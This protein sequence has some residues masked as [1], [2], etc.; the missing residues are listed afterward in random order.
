M[1]NSCLS[2]SAVGFSS[3]DAGQLAVYPQA[4]CSSQCISGIEAMAH[5]LGHP[6]GLDPRW[7]GKQHSGVIKAPAIPEENIRAFCPCEGCLIRDELKC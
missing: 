5:C 3:N 1:S 7:L 2:R 6:R 4:Y